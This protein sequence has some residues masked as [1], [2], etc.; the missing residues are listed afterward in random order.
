[1]DQSTSTLHLTHEHATRTSE[2]ERESGQ[3][4]EEIE[5]LKSQL[6]EQSHEHARQKEALEHQLSQS[7]A[8][9]A[10]SIESMGR[11]NESLK[12]QLAD[13]QREY[14]TQIELLMQRISLAHDDKS[15]T[16]V[17]I[18]LFCCTVAPLTATRPEQARTRE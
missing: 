4:R 12:Q 2:A 9:Y 18:T 7:E 15:E 17:R 13:Q 5:S 1:M 16:K 14:A 8:S 3:L 10:T 6:L 11:E